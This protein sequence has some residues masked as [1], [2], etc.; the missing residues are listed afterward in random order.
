[1]N[2]LRLELRK[3]NIRPYFF[4]VLAIFICILG[5]MYIFAWVPHLDSGDKNAAVLFSSYQGIVS[6]S[7]AIALMAF[8]ALSSA[9]GFLY[10]I[11]EYRGANAVLLFCYPINRKSILWAKIQLLLFFT[12]ITLFVALFGSFLIFAA[13]EDLF[14][15]VDNSLHFS[16]FAIAF[17]NT[18]VLI[19]LANGIALCSIRIGFI[20]KSNSITVISAILGSML[21]VNVVAQINSRFLAVLSMAVVIF[22]IGIVLTFNLARK[23]DVMEI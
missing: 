22:L 18:L 21:L 2:L 14:S 12:S 9:M 17:R 10:V 6:I 11:K 16:D 4:S 20:R 7:G 15:L 8:S 23:I 1:M 3:S 5:L 13:T 19:L